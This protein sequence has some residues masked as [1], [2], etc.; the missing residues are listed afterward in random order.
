[1]LM[2]ISSDLL[3]NS[4]AF[5]KYV[6]QFNQYLEACEN[7]ENTQLQC[8]GNCQLAKQIILGEKSGDA[9]QTEPSI[10]VYHFA[11]F[12]QDIKEYI[13]VPYTY[14]TSHLYTPKLLQGVQMLIFHPPQ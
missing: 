13:Q 14:H 4:I 12:T 6:Y 1:M 11:L 3:A 8:N 2:V 9:E 7:K 5:G 10:E